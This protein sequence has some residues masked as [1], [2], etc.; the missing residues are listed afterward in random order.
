MNRTR[1]LALAVITSLTFAGV[2]AHGAD[3]AKKPPMHMHKSEM[4]HDKPDKDVAAQYKDEATVLLEKAESHRKLAEHYRHR[5]PQKGAASYE[6][7]A[8]HCDKLADLYTQAAKE[9]GAVAD[10][11]KE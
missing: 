5:K 7:V 8:K 2:S 10:E 3:E 6:S 1:L 4:N 9:A 11:L